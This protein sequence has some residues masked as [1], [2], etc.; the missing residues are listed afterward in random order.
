MALDRKKSITQIPAA[1]PFQSYFDS[2]LLQTALLQQAMGASIVASTL[3]SAQSKGVGVALHAQSDTP[4]AFR[5]RGGDADSAEIIVAPGQKM[6]VGSFDTFDY[7]LPFG[8]LGGGTALIYVIHHTGADYDLG[9]GGRSPIIFQ[10]QRMIIDSGLAPA[11]WPGTFRANWPRTFPWPSA[12]M[13]A[14][15]TPQTGAALLDV[16]PEIVILRLRASPAA[17]VTLSLVWRGTD[18]L[19][20]DG[21]GALN[22]TDFSSVDV[23]FPAVPAG[24]G[25]F[26]LI[27]LPAEIHRLAC[28]AGGVNFV[29]PTGALEG[30]FIDIVRYAR[31]G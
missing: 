15:G 23:S 4:V 30:S 16:E 7:G 5:F 27:T 10:R 12:T 21:A 2:A 28:A 17:A 20:I 11:V 18:D 19:D 25:V 8:W 1:Y 31:L 14:A 29:D 6:L 22:V 26:P 3:Q 24:S 13:G 9:G